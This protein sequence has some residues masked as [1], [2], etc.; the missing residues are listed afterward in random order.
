MA[1]DLAYTNAET[2][3]GAGGFGVGGGKLRDR[4]RGEMSQR[5][6]D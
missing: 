6:K 1:A 3:K 2:R 5:K 4:R